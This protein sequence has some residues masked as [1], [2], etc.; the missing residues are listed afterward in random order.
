MALA[1]SY[2]LWSRICHSYLLVLIHLEGKKLTSSNN[3]MNLTRISRV[4]FWA[5]VIT[6][7]G[8]AGRWNKIND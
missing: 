1:G 7:A 5:S 4:R 3:C 2:V 6:R 8:Y